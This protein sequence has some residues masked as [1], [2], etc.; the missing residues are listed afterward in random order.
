MG[1]GYSSHDTLVMDSTIVSNKPSSPG[2]LMKDPPL[3]PSTVV[4]GPSLDS[5]VLVSGV[6]SGADVVCLSPLLDSLVV[7]AVLSLDSA[8]LVLGVVGTVD[9]DS[10]PLA[11]SVVAAGPSLAPISGMD[12]V[13][14]SFFL[15][16]SNFLKVD[17]L[18]APSM[19][20][21]GS[22]IDPPLVPFL[23]S[24]F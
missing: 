4:A 8:I 14:D 20:A 23:G 15:S 18:L 12:F 9:A 11:P 24:N 10:L 16:S 21:S 3:A 17:P 22:K 19:V 6:D 5:F 1:S 7:V 2:I 13:A